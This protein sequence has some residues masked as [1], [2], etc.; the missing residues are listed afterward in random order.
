MELRQESH[1]MQTVR[2]VTSLEEGLK[3]GT[4]EKRRGLIDSR[5]KARGTGKKKREKKKKKSECQF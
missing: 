1:W 4:P 2:S 3:K 5:W